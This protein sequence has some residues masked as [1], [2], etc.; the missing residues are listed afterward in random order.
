MWSIWAENLVSDTG[1]QIGLQ[2]YITMDERMNS[3]QKDDIR[4]YSWMN[5]REMS[6]Y[7]LYDTKEFQFQPAR[8][9]FLFYPQSLFTKRTPFYEYMNPHYNPKTVW[10]PSQVYNEDT[11]SNKTMS[12][13]WTEAQ[14][15]LPRV[16][17]FMFDYDDKCTIYIQHCLQQCY[18]YPTK[19]NIA[20]HGTTTWNISNISVYRVTK[21]PIYT[22]HFMQ[23]ILWPITI[24]RYYQNRIA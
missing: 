24:L 23:L 8:V 22:M 3:R 2:S 16:L 17:A 5:H 11:F 6:I 13:W 9:H 21:K 18:Q 14:E 19:T 1:N 12:F 15:A 20:E 7:Q 4:V 10:R